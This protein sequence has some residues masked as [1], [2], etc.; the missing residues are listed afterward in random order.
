[1]G[2]SNYFIANRG[3]H[4]FCFCEMFNDHISMCL[5]FAD[6]LDDMFLN[7]NVWHWEFKLAHIKIQFRDGHTVTRAASSTSAKWVW[8]TRRMVTEPNSGSSWKRLPPPEAKL[9]GTAG[10]QLI[11]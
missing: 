7:F 5:Q 10:T 2:G 11:S 4:A 9:I 8:P 6:I 3:K 1:M